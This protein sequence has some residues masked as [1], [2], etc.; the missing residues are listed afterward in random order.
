MTSPNDAGKLTPS[1]YDTLPPPVASK[2]P[3]KRQ[4][5]L[6]KILFGVL[7]GAALFFAKQFFWGEGGFSG[8][9]PKGPKYV[10]AGMKWQSFDPVW[11]RFDESYALDLKL[12]VTSAPPTFDG[13]RTRQLNGRMMRAICGAILTK[14]PRPPENVTRNNIYRLG[15]MF[16]ANTE[17]KWGDPLPVPI[18][19]GSC[20]SKDGQ[21][22]FDWAYPGQ[23]TGW[24]PVRYEQGTDTGLTITF[25]RRSETNLAYD[26]VDLEFACQALFRDAPEKMR[27]LL[28]ARDQVTIRIVKGLA[29][30]IGWIGLYKMQSFQIVNDTCIPMGNVREG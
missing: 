16:P 8:N 2:P 6:K 3:P 27:N 10:A 22:I 15:L 20:L 12:V 23:L 7:I 19:D 9:G 24:S 30:G 13:K 25:A 11:T 26:Q 28:E 21:L 29:G 5:P 17:E 4:L 1:R 14:L 18:Q